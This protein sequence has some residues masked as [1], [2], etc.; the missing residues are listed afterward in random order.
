MLPAE[1]ARGGGARTTRSV[2]R[3]SRTA[4]FQVPGATAITGHALKGLESV[5]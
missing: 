3:A 1:D 5:I 4:A 2:A